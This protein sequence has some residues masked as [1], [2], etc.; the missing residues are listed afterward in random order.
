MLNQLPHSIQEEI[1]KYLLLNDFVK[2]KQ[3]YDTWKQ[4]L[5]L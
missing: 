5:A 2:A 4:V 1:K 3:V